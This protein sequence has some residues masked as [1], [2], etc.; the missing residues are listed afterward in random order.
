MK[1]I[2]YSLENT[3]K[4]GTYVALLPSAETKAS[5]LRFC[6]SLD[7]PDL[8]DSDEYHTTLIYSK[9]G[10]PDVVKEDFGLP[11]EAMMKGFKILGTDTKVLVIELFC[12]AA[13]RLHD[14]FR[15]EYGAHHDYDDYVPHITIATNFNGILPSAIFDDAVLF[16]GITIEELSP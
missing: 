8:V 14:R 4:N 11:I 9:V 6:A 5:L 16:T 3:H 2:N 15:K 12:P 7:V 1:H 13:K 10:C